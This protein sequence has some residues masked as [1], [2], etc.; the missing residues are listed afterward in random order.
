M[1]ITKEKDFWLL[2][3]PHGMSVHNGTSDSP[4]LLMILKKKYPQYQFFLPYRLDKETSGLIIVALDGEVTYDLQKAIND[5][6]ESEKFYQSI[7]RG[8]LKQDEGLW[9]AAL[10]DKA[11]GRKNPQGLL[12]D[13]KESKTHFQVQQKN[14]FFTLVENKIETGRQHQ[15]R[16]HSCLAGHSIVGDPRYGEPN[17]N[18][19]IAELYQ[20]ERLFLHATRIKFKYKSKKFD[21]SSHLPKEFL[22]LM[23]A[24]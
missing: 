1:I 2:D 23:A 11:E 6:P 10:S 15:I 14:K 5:S 20:A 3:K 9:D 21:F 16:K 18:Q 4:D 19:K 24:T 12:K 13:R 22:K 8:Q 7:L 17:Y